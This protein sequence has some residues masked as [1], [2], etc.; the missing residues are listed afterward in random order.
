MRRLMATRR[1]PSSSTAGCPAWS[2]ATTK[3]S[4]PS[5]SAAA[6]C[7][8]TGSPPTSSASS[9]PDGS[10]APHTRPRPFKKASWSVSVE[11]TVRGMWKAL[12][13]RDWELVK[14][15]LASDC[16]YFDVPVGPAASARG[17]EDIEKR[18]RIAW[19]ALSHY[20]NHDGL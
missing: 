4:S 5:L 6:P 1:T 7:S 18:I 19:D 13:A 11:D 16:I 2:T 12:S 8:S 3:P 10:C 14:T 15:Y 17:P 20:E 9:A